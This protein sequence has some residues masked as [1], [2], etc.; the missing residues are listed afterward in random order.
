VTVRTEKATGVNKRPELT[1]G[2]SSQHFREYYYL[3]SE[4]VE[5]CRKERLSTSGGKAELADRIETYLQAGERIAAAKPIAGKSSGCPEV[6]PAAVTPASVIEENF[7]CSERHRDFFK[8]VIG[9]SFKFNVEFQTWLKRNAGKTYA[10][11]V[12]AYKEIAER[13]KTTVTKIGGQFEYN[14]YI[15]AFFDANKGRT[16]AQAITCWKYKKSLP[17]HNRYE[18]SDLEVLGPVRGAES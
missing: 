4:L 6:S 14:A 7:R 1:Q 11:A 18:A 16:L 9:G 2:L 15:R 8:S 13:K 5:F 3:K 12:L 10:D 17:G